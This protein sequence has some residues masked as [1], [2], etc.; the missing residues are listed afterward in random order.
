M[1]RYNDALTKDN[2]NLIESEDEADE[3]QNQMIDDDYV[4]QKYDTIESQFIPNHQVIQSAAN[5]RPVN[6]KIVNN[7]ASQNSGH[8]FDTASF[9]PQGGYNQGGKA[10]DSAQKDFSNMMNITANKSSSILD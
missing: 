9:Y 4:Q 1:G 5:V 10:I 3:A 6:D 2:N 8:T 7:Y